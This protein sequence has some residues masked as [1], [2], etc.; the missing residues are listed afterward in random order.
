MPA[1]A[2]GNA[3]SRQGDISSLKRLNFDYEYPEGLKLKPGSPLHGKLVDMLIRRARESA[4]EVSH[5]FD[6]WRRIDRTMT[7]YIDLSESEQQLKQKDPSKPLSIVFPYSYA[8]LE[9]MLGYLLSAFMQEPVF[10]YEGSGPEDT[11][12]SILLT[13]IID[14]QVARSKMLLNF[15]TMFRDA[16][17]YGFGAVGTDWKV[18]KGFQIQKQT[19]L[20]MFGPPT[21]K[22]ARK[23]TTL[24]EGNT[25]FNIDP[26]RMLP[27]PNCPIGNAQGGEFLGWTEQT[28]LMNLLQEEEQAETLFNVRYL[29]EVGARRTTIYPDDASAR[30]QKAGTSSFNR[31]EGITHPVDVVTMNVKLIPE[32]WGLGDGEYPELWRFKVAADMVLIEA[33][34]VELVHNKIPVGICAPDF[35]GYSV[36]P[37]SRMEIIHG[38]QHTLD[39]MFNAHVA[40]VRKAINNTLI[41]D[42]YMVNVND[43][44]N[45]KP[46]G[47]YR[48]RRPAWGRGVKGAVEQLPVTDITRGHMA[49]S[50]IIREAMD[51]ISGTDGSMMGSLRQGGPERLTSSEFQSTQQGG[52]TR[53]GRMARVI[54]IQAMQ[55]LG[56]FFASNT[57]QFMS[58]EAYVNASGEWE[59]QL[60]QTYGKQ[61]IPVG[62]LDLLVN[63]DFCVRDGSL[64]GGS[65]AAVWVKMFEMVSGS[66]QLQQNFDLVRIFGKVAEAGGEK[67]IYDFVNTQVQP[68]EAVEQ[69]VQEGN[70]VPI[71]EVM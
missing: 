52:M 53:M 26:Y 33:R 3:E 20:H 49:D 11:I 5:R 68:D 70:M 8:V 13:K 4:N 27:D 10:R 55:D 63:Y 51:K 56:L 67:N 21:V 43:I 71:D 29:K 18:E 58:Q 28:N 6:A 24:W 14:Q 17:C 31:N 7:A 61:Q 36:S 30:N 65:D 12:G 46:G 62:P 64:P 38:L 39:W 34:R 19:T 47:I 25:L 59:Q 37:I 42:P 32:D 60:L 2:Y 48:L 54:G 9:T 45:P 23:R 66:Q 16:L 41:V 15:H 50:A 44:K 57:Q 69:G 1:L 40:N 22:K 35:D